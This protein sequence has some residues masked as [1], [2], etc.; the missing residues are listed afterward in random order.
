VT[1]LSRR[2][3]L[4]T[5]VG[6]ALVPGDAFGDPLPAKIQAELL[7]KLAPYDRNLQARAEGRVRVRVVRVGGPLSERW[8]AQLANTLGRWETI[9]GLPHSETVTVYKDAAELVKA[10]KDDRT[11]IVV[12]APELRDEVEKL[13]A[14]FDGVNVLTVTPDAELVQRGIILGFELVSGKPKLFY[15]LEQAH[16]QS[17]SMSAEVLKL[18]TVYQ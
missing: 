12:L 10:C 9:A 7:V 4:A 3:V 5:L 16:R 14:A 13:R 6:I 15:N 11:T 1:S 8:A 18:M 17:I 2:A